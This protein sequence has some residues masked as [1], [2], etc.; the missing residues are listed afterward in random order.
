MFFFAVSPWHAVI[1]GFQVVAIAG[2]TLS[3]ILAFVFGDVWMQQGNQQLHLII[4]FFLLCVC[5]AYFR[6]ESS[7]EIQLDA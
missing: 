4:S 3:F 2:K 5:D 7:L 1:T 6:I